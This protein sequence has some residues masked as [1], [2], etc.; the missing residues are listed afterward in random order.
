M[1]VLDSGKIATGSD[2]SYGAQMPFEFLRITDGTPTPSALDDIYI[3][4]YFKRPGNLLTDLP[5]GGNAVISELK[6]GGH[7]GLY[8]GDLRILTNILKDS[9]GNLYWKT[10]CDRAANGIFSADPSGMLAFD[11]GGSF[12]YWQE[13]NKSVP[14]VLDAWNK[15]EIYIHRHAKNGIVL[16]AINDQIICYH[17]G[18]T[19]GEFGYSWGRVIIHN[20]YG[21]HKIGSAEIAR[22]E[23]W[24]YPKNGSV[25]QAHAASLLYR[26]G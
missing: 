1:E 5:V 20:V 21:S 15:C 9:A 2:V 3:R 8:G 4:Y 25:L 13:S 24:N 18:R 6:T 26:Y 23:I 16:I 19:I 11:V 17:V 7:T 12:K 14:V 10:E 22:P